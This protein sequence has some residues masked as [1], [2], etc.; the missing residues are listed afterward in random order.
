MS[1]VLK[2]FVWFYNEFGVSAISET[3][4]N[5]WLIIL[6]RACRMFAYGTNSLILG[7]HCAI[8][9]RKDQSDEQTAIFFSALK[10]SDHQIGIFMTLTL[11]GD[12]FLGTVLTLI[13]DKVGR[14]K[15]LIGGSFL[16]VLSGVIFAV[17]ENFFILLLASVV[18]VISVTGGD[19]G[20]FRSIEEYVGGP[21][22]EA[23]QLTCLRSVISQLTTPRTRADVLAWYV[24][25]SAVGS[26]LG[27]EASG[28]II[29][30]LE[31][32][33]GWTPVNIYHTLFWIY[34]VM[35]LVNAL[36]MFLLTDAC[37][38]NPTDDYTSVPQDEAESTNAPPPQPMPTSTVPT[39]T[40]FFGRLT[41]WLTTSLSQ[42]SPPTLSIMWKLWILLA[43]DSVADGMVPYTLTNYYMDNKFSPRKSTLG[44]ITSASYF[45]AAIGSTFAGP[46]ARKIGLINTMVFTHVPSSAAVLF[47]P[48]PPYLWATALLLLVRA[49]LNNMDQAPRSAFIAAVVKGEERTAVMGI[50]ATVRTLAATTGPT[51]TGL[52]AGKDQFWIAFVV[53][54][55]CRLAY[56]FG[57]YKLFVDVKLYEHE[58]GG[59]GAEMVEQ[60]S[61]RRSVEEEDLEMQS[62]A[63]SDSSG[64]WVGG[65][66][67][68]TSKG[69]ARGEMLRPGGE[70]TRSRSPRRADDAEQIL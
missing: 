14:R 33:D 16:M 55:V 62:L 7:K 63:G 28:R 51:F 43:L 19:F 36:L 9:Q 12:V 17:F 29:H 67:D 22:A 32:L 56:D 49:G 10:Y 35:G 23:P 13:A 38:L 40:T 15:V 1:A 58:E 52:L 66:N 54:G 45:L 31:S 64:D 50:T 44:D 39:P 70:R 37:E 2:P 47:F 68:D 65:G 48:L 20:P 61:G 8:P 59:K 41:S 46:L 69:G 53:A 3:G 4:R 24:T 11:V 27:S 42:I 30:Y 5:A 21:I 26:S 25:I 6:A 57:L 18:G 34:A 60:Q